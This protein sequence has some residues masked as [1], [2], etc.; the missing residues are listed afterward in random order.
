M[1]KNKKYI[2]VLGNGQMGEY[3]AD[4]LGYDNLVDIV[5]KE[6]RDCEIKNRKYINGDFSKLD[7]IDFTFYDLIVSCVPAKFGFSVLKKC[8][9]EGKNCVDLSFC[10]EDVFQLDEL[11]KKN[12]CCII[13]DAGLAP[14]LTNLFVGREL[15]KK[16]KLDNV[17]IYVGGVSQSPFEKY[18]YKITWSVEDLLE[19]YL[20]PARAIILNKIESFNPFATIINVDING[21]KMESFLADGCRT[22]LRL[23]DR[24]RFLSERTLRWTGHMC[25]VGRLID[26]NNFVEEIKKNCINGDDT[27]VF[28]IR[29]EEQWIP[30]KDITMIYQNYSG[31]DSNSAMRIT[32]A[33]TCQFVSEMVLNDIFNEPGIHPLEHIGQNPIA[34]QFLIDKLKETG[35]YFETNSTDGL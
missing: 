2:L 25:Q 19:E 13:P 23:K 30:I 7:E 12:N 1:N 26:N 6:V 35:V 3:V 18:G 34:F 20:R 4:C 8:A 5:D 11:A 24:I 14:G 32:T 22:L 16:K 10:K 28:Q 27:V 21:I 33:G 17:E 9:Q 31:C 15:Y 29:F